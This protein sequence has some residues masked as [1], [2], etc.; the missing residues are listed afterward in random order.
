M[1]E[2]GLQVPLIPTMSRSGAHVTQ[3]QGVQSQAATT[4]VT[5]AMTS[6]TTSTITM[7]TASTIKPVLTAGTLDVM[8][9]TPGQWVGGT[10][11]VRK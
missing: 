8:P 3:A 9:S 1:E 10:I 11:Q 6:I 2:S 4:D 7:T 5:I